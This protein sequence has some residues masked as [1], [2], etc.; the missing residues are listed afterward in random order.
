M[1]DLRNT[2]EE[3]INI[4]EPNDLPETPSINTNKE[5]SEVQVRTPNKNDKTRWPS[6]TC[7][8]SQ[9]D[10]DDDDKETKYRLDPK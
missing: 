8:N 6:S 9:D 4:Y 2:R 10:V 5:E 3:A 1:I 7:E